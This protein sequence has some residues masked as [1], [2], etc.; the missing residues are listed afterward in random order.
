MKQNEIE[1]EHELLR[2]GGVPL[3]KFSLTKYFLAT[4]LVTAV[5]VAVA[6]SLK[7]ADDVR[8]DILSTSEHEAI[9]IARHLNRQVHERFLFPTLAEAGSVDLENPEH[10]A[11]LDAVVKLSVA[12]LEVRAVY[13]FD[14][15]GRITYSTHAEHR[16]FHVRSNPNYTLATEGTP[17]SILVDRGNPLDI[18]GRTEDVSLL[19]TYVP[20]LPLD[21]EGK[22]VG[23]QVGVIEIY[24]DAT[25]LVGETRHAMGEVAMTSTLAICVLM[26]A[27]WLWVRKADRVIHE[28]TDELLE[29]NARLATLSADLER[30]VEDRTR[31][32]LRAETLASVGTLAA[33]VAHEVNNPMAAI[34][35]S[36]EGLLR[37]SNSE[38]L[39]SHEEFADF[40]T[41]LGI[42]RDEAF[43]VKEITRNLLDFSRAEGESMRA[44]VDLVSLLKAANRLLDHQAKRDRIQLVFEPP[45]QSVV[46]RADAARL[47]QVVMNLT[48]NALAEAPQGSTIRWILERDETEVVV[49]CEDEGPG[50]DPADLDRAIEP[51]YTRKPAG[52]G[53]GLGLAI[54]YRVVTE[55]GGEL[56]L[57]NRA[58]GGARVEIRLPVSGEPRERE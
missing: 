44:P 2:L 48:V 53:T 22:P 24:Q 20:V 46:I 37:R 50:F 52:E 23:A 19:E 54:A 9:R 34:A 12:E 56:Q 57:S 8:T 40:P 47:R 42:I 10:L 35:T 58:G 21:A 17:N 32:L 16:G 51:F 14:L 1:Q 43:R 29:A 18:A 7:A 31:R 39:L 28:R 25:E 33:G 11:R 30:Q 45:A 6:F 26:L 5:C 36:A 49:A 4:G 27:L 55:H 15:E 13:F 3:S 38:A 41:Y